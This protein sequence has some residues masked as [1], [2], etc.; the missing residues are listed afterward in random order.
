MM[1][2]SFGMVRFN[3]CFYFRPNFCRF[4]S[5]IEIWGW[6]THFLITNFLCIY[7]YMS[8]NGLTFGIF[9]IST[10]SMVLYLFL[11]HLMEIFQKTHNFWDK[12]IVKPYLTVVKYF[13]TAINTKFSAINHY[14][15][16]FNT[17]YWLWKEGNIM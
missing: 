4:F 7:D 2:K 9:N 12:T 16:N 3:K 5:L 17:K 1:K 8:K 15:T 13:E 11:L 14:L 10:F 6:L